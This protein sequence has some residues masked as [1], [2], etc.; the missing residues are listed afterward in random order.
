MPKNKGILLVRQHKLTRAILQ[1]CWS[2]CLV[3]FGVNKPSQPCHGNDIGHVPDVV[4]Y[5]PRYPKCSIGQANKYIS[6]NCGLL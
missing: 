2:S 5:I 4:Q 6:R 1:A 3:K